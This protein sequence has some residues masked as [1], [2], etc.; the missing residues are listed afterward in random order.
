MPEKFSCAALTESKHYNFLPGFFTV[1]QS[2]VRK[3]M[4]VS[5][6]LGQIRLVRLGSIFFHILR[7]TVHTAKNP[8]AV[9]RN[10][11]QGWSGVGFYK[12]IL[13]FMIFDYNFYN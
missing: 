10:N 5:V 13:K 4:L 8:R 2:A 9:S 12:Y 1:G 3:K 6:R 7:R 11:V